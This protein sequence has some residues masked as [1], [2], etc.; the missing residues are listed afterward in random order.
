VTDK[1]RAAVA[2]AAQVVLEA[3][4]QY[5][6]STRADLYDPLTM[7]TPRVRAAHCQAQ[8]RFAPRS[9][10]YRRPRAGHSATR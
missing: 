9:T 4:V 5:P 6:T 2:V 1:Q 10:P 3:R 8:R 7:P